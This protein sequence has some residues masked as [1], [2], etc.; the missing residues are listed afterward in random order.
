MTNQDIVRL[1]SRLTVLSA[2]CTEEEER[3]LEWIASHLA[4][5]FGKPYLFVGGK[6]ILSD[7]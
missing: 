1:E 6:R 2:H 5:E 7:S 4:A 3:T